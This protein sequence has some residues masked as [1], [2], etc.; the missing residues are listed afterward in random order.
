MMGLDR[1][2]EGGASEDAPVRSN[3]LKPGVKHVDVI[4]LVKARV[5]VRV[6]VRI[7]FNDIYLVLR[8]PSSTIHSPATTTPLPTRLE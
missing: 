1:Y 8:A 7:W 2:R 6:R 5:K 4:H 3:Y